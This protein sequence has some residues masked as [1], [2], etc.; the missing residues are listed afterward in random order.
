MTRLSHFLFAFFYFTFLICAFNFS[1]SFWLL[2]FLSLFLLFLWKFLG[3]LAWHNLFI[4]LSVMFFLYGN[5]L[6]FEKGMI[7]SL[8]IYLWVLFYLSAI[9]LKKYP[10]FY[11]FTRNIFFASIL[12]LFFLTLNI[13]FFKLHYSI[14]LVGFLLTL[15]SGSLIHWKILIDRLQIDFLDRIIL[16][17]GFIEISFFLLNLSGGFF[18]YPILSVFWF[19]VLFD[20]LES[21]KGKNLTNKFSFWHILLPILVSI[22]LL[23]LLKI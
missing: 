5:S 18:L 17:L 15:G 20:L 3:G 1:F 22:I 7:I 16:F 23:F 4:L 2:A 19:Y 13:F 12:F 6:F 8:V 11:D 21:I 9:K 14:W 10:F